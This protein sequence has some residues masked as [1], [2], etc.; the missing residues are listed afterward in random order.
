MKTEEQTPDDRPHWVRSLDENLTHT[1]RP[2]NWNRNFVNGET[3]K[4][5]NESE[6]SK[7]SASKNNG[8]SKHGFRLRKKGRS[9]TQPNNYNDKRHNAMLY[10]GHYSDTSSIA[11]RYTTSSE[12][13]ERKKT[14]RL[15]LFLLLLIVAFIIAALIGWLVYYLLT[16]DG[17]RFEPLVMRKQKLAADGSLRILN[18]TYTDDMANS[19]S[20]DFKRIAEPLCREIDSF[21]VSSNLSSHYNGCQLTEIRNV[22]VEPGCQCAWSPEGS[23]LVNFRLLFNST[24][25]DKDTL[26]WEVYRII[27]DGTSKHYLGSLIYVLV[28]HFLVDIRANWNRPFDGVEV[29]TSIP[30]F[31]LNYT[32]ALDDRKSKEFRAIGTPF[33]NDVQRIL[34]SGPRRDFADRFSSCEVTHLRP[35]PDRVDFGVQLRGR[36]WRNVQKKFIYVLMSGARNATIQAQTV[37]MIGPL[38][39]TPYN[40]DFKIFPI[41]VT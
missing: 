4:Q 10:R 12:R 37:K 38:I 21:F 24:T 1:S 14:R 41:N 6:A 11:S 22:A 31:N 16:R 29:K 35:R 25:T 9:P 15:G 13:R 19:S 36:E 39:V 40:L 33:C 26:R 32:R 17:P 5:S 30:V 27:E 28:T 2:D 8:N 7:I 20:A 34:L 3:A 18:E 23:L